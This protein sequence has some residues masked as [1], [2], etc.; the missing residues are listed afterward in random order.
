[1][2]EVLPIGPMFCK[3]LLSKGLTIGTARV[4]FYFRTDV[5]NP[6][7]PIEGCGIAVSPFRGDEFFK[8][9][10]SLV[11]ECRRPHPLT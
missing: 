5:L 6:A 7:Q 4:T 3:G 8:Q 1:M 9:G 2:F 10:D 11:F